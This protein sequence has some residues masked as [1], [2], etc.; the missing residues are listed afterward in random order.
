[1]ENYKPNIE[2]LKTYYRQYP[3]IFDEYFAYHCQNTDDRLGQSIQR[4]PDSFDQIKQVHQNIKPII[5]EVGYRYEG[6]YGVSF[7]IDINLIV[8]GYGSN[9][10]THRQYVPNIT[11]ALERL[12]PNVNHLK[13]IVA[14][15]FGHAAQ[16]ILSNEA[17]INWSEVRWDSPLT[18]LSQEG[19]ATY[20]SRCIIPNLNPSIYFSYDD[21]GSKWL[22]FAETHKNRIKDAFR[23][24]FFNQTS[25][26]MFREWF[27]INGGKQF[28]YS[29][30]G[31]YLAD[32]FFQDQVIKSGERKA[33]M[34]WKDE[35]FYDK[36]KDWL[37]RQE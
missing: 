1:M 9:A 22:A 4:Y 2:F 14:H 20:L 36:A 32:L 19:T 30:L 33:I 15:E 16:N 3:D 17:G 23:E 12:S 18:W 29:R 27:S 25:K 26:D 6:L 24:D 31:Y 11:F 34:S 21:E 13:V 7:P 10:Y 35:G 8:G 37:S 28:G 5:A